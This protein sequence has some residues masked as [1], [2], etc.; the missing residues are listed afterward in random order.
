MQTWTEHFLH[1]RHSKK[2]EKNCYAAVFE[3]AIKIS[4]FEQDDDLIGSKFLRSFKNADAESFAEIDQLCAADL[5]TIDCK[6]DFLLGM[7]RQFQKI[8][9]RQFHQLIHCHAQP[10]QFHGNVKRQLLDRPWPVLLQQ[11]RQLRFRSFRSFWLFHRF[12]IE[13]RHNRA[14]SICFLSLRRETAE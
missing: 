10:C 12:L 4:N 5:L 2:I 14:I 13:L 8:A 3:I 9:G 6:S 7:D 11:A 1:M